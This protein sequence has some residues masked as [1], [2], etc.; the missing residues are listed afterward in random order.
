MS[1]TKIE[2]NLPSRGL[3]SD[4]HWDNEENS[5]RMSVNIGGVSP[6]DSLMNSNIF[7]PSNLGSVQEEN[8]VESTQ[9]TKSSYVMEL[10]KKTWALISE[11]KKEESQFSEEQRD[12]SVQVSNMRPL[13]AKPERKDE[14]DMK[15][16]L[17]LF[18]MDEESVKQF[19]K[20]ENELE[21]NTDSPQKN[22]S[23]ID[24]AAIEVAIYDVHKNQVKIRQKASINLK[25]SILQDAEEKK[26]LWTQYLDLKKEAERRAKYSKIFTWMTIGTGIIGGSLL[27]GGIIAAAV[28][29]GGMAIPAVLAIATGL[30]GVVGGCS[31]IS[32][33]VFSFLGNKS[34]GEAF[35]V[36]EKGNLK[37]DE[38][39]A[40]LQN[41]E[42][43][44]NSVTEVWSNLGRLLR[45]TPNNIFR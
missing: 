24:E 37:K 27:V 25:D 35:V 11:P 7:D 42:Q 36:K 29:T 14:V 4:P 19:D 44:E 15:D 32:G 43:T 28:G 21:S 45:N 12:K 18:K 34:Q 40:K 31:G 41:I 26:R 30:A 39:M 3:I 20:I 9:P 16:F 6:Q 8:L 1:E 13:L 23:D 10:L 5:K 33:S 38:I 17:A 2:S 22:F